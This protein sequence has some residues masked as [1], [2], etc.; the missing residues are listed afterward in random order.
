MRSSLHPR[1]AM[2][3]HLRRLW[4]IAIAVCGAAYP[5]NAYAHGIDLF[6]HTAGD[7][8]RGTVT[9]SDGSPAAGVRVEVSWDDPGTSHESEE[10]AATVQTD[11]AGKF[12]FTP[13]VD[14][15]YLFICRTADGHRAARSVMFGV[16][17]DIESAGVLGE[18]TS[19]AIQQ[20]LSALQEQLHDYERRTRIRDVIGG[21]GYIL[22]LAGIV[23]LMKTRR[24]G[25]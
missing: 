24:R 15:E 4:L 25:S 14:S 16:D 18:Q 23:A 13:S 3:D 9:Y 22:G 19:T 21:I 10:D 5:F 20:Q 2:N 17:G 8:I 1:R 12:I 11:E 7:E 6:A